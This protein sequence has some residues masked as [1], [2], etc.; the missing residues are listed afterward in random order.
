MDR[1]DQHDLAGRAPFL[2]QNAENRIYIDKIPRPTGFESRDYLVHVINAK[3]RKYC[4]VDD[5]AEKHPGSHQ[6]GPERAESAVCP[7]DKTAISWEGGGELGS[8]ESFRDTPDE[9]EDEEAENG[10]KG[11][12][13]LA[14]RLFPKRAAG[15][16]EVDE[17]D[18][19][20]EG[21]FLSVCGGGCGGRG[22][23]DGKVLMNESLIRPRC[24]T[25]DVEQVDSLGQ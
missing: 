1:Q 9:W 23:G 17:K 6:R 4:D 2:Q 10:E 3:N 13:G 25:S 18:K 24:D 12:G 7:D 19:R 21:E 22:S 8:D 11:S 15:D 20:D 14:C 5:A 16:F